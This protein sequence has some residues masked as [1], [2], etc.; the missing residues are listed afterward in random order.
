MVGGDRRVQDVL[1]VQDPQQTPRLAQEPI[2]IRLL[3]LGEQALRRRA[4]GQNHLT[5]FR[6]LIEKDISALKSNESRGER[7]EARLMPLIRMDKDTT[8]YL[9]F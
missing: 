7:D 9:I 4:L 3:I 6:I 8:Y 2:P 5:T 1:L